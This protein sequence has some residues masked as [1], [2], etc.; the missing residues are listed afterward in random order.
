MGLAGDQVQGSGVVSDHLG[1]RLDHVLETLAGI[2]Q[3]E[4]RDQRPAF[5]A[6][7]GLEPLTPVRLDHRHPVGNDPGRFGEAVVGG[8]D[9]NG[10]RGHDDHLVAEGGDAPHRLAD[11]RRRIG[12]DRVHG[13]HHRLAELLE[14]GPEMVLVGAVGHGAGDQA[15]R[16][17]DAVEAELVLHVDG[18]GIRAVDRSGGVAVGVGIALAYP[19]AHL[20]RVGP[21]HGRLLDGRD[22]AGDRWI[23]G[24]DRGD[25]ARRE[26]G[27]AA[28][29]GYG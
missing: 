22:P 10:A 15:R 18:V 6:E 19:P 16:R 27:D 5:H 12:E 3:T 8:E 28:S 23:G 13:R 29:A 11:G 14:E 9:L 17:P 2:D 25:E 21:E 1:H 4:G 26:G 7:L 20:G 24:A